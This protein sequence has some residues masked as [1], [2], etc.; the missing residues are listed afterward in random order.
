MPAVVIYTTC[1]SETEASRIGR[2]IVAERLAACAN[3]LGNMH[4]IYHW[5]GALEDGAETVLLLKTRAEF[6]DAVIA[7]VRELHSFSVPCII[8]LPVTAGSPDFL[9]WIDSE[10]EGGRT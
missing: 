3:I 1:A 9:A 5:Q 6:A 7:R 2:S 4:S 8:A 10:T